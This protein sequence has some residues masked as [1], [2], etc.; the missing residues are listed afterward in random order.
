MLV[1]VWLAPIGTLVPFCV[2][3]TPVAFVTVQLS[4]TACPTVT[5]VGFAV[6]VAVGPVGGGGAVTFT[7]AWA[8]A[9][10]VPEGP[11]AVKVNVVVPTVLKVKDIPGEVNGLP[12]RAT[13]LPFWSRLMV[14]AFCVCQLT[15]TL[16]PASTVVGVT[17]IDAVGLVGVGFAGGIG[18]DGVV[19]GL[20]G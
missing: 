5:V 18:T 14:L 20:P 12:S 17:V 1:E 10:V 11:V 13:A 9:A 15:V 6:R 16:P 7:E 2:S 3:V 8:V 4:A 19:V